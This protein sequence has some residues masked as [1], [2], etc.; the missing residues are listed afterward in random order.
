MA[1]VIQRVEMKINIRFENKHHCPFFSLNTSNCILPPT[2][3]LL[4]QLHTADF[5][6][7]KNLDIL[8]GIVTGT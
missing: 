8:H 3:H 5:L 2:H 6:D 7:Y 1:E 4:L